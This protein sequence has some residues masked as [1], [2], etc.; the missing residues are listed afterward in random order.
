MTIK[1]ELSLEIAAVLLVFGGGGVYWPEKTEK[2]G[3]SNRF[4]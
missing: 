4:L 2:Q 3:K 1:L